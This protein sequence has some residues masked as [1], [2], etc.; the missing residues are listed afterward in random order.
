MITRFEKRE[1][2]AE[3]IDTVLGLAFRSNWDPQ[4]R[5]VVSYRNISEVT[6][7]YL[8]TGY[9]KV[10]N[11]ATVDPNDLQ[12]NC[13]HRKWDAAT[14]TCAICGKAWSTILWSGKPCCAGGLSNQPAQY[15]GGK[16]HSIDCDSLKAPQLPEQP[17]TAQIDYRPKPSRNRCE[18]GGW[19]T[20]NPNAHAHYC[21]EYRK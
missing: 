15:S 9:K 20:S 5:S 8:N 16:W 3:F 6:T 13:D 11:T 19:A 7:D 17:P 18:C 10:T 2:W 1:K 21:P 14:D 4:W 12:G